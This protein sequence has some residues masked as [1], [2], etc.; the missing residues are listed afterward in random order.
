M[1]GHCQSQIVLSVVLHA[2]LVAAW[3]AVHF[4]AV[5][6]ERGFYCDD[7]SISK[8]YKVPHRNLP[9]ISLIFHK[10]HHVLESR[11]LQGRFIYALFS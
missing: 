9:T 10:G 6:F 2:V 3:M 4:T 8:P 7:K 11:N 1:P 5:P